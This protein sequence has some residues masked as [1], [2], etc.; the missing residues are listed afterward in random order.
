[1]RSDV[2]GEVCGAVVKVAI[3]GASG[4]V[5]GELLRLLSAHPGVQVGALTAGE[6]AGRRLGDVHPH[7]P[8]LADSVLLP[9][10]SASLAGHDVVLLALPHG[11]SAELAAVL[12]EQ[13][14]V[15]DCGADHR[16]REAA[17]WESFYGT[18]HP[19]TWV[20]G[21]PELSGQREE[22]ADARR[23]A[24]PGCFPTATALALAP[25][26]TQGLVD[27]ADVVV[28]AATGT[29]GAGRTPRQDLLGSEVMGSASAYGV[30][31]THR[32]TPE[33]EQVLRM[34]GASGAT[35]SFTPVLVPMA[36]G[37]LATCS[38]PV[39]DG[40]HADDV[41][42]AYEKATAEEPFWHLLPPGRWPQSQ[43]VIGSNSAQVQVALDAHAGRVVAV[44]AIDNLTKGTAG[45]AMQSMNIALGLPETT[46]L[47]VTGVAP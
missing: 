18:P 36:R 11:H 24:V 4:Y 37:I 5:G 16:L 6:H 28:V 46:G 7:L 45:G 25:A 8:H 23:I 29:S 42:A 21:L 44:A 43:A 3:A 2:E 31:G 26:V 27:T 41:H 10:S 20:Y 13:T 34:A 22:I 12:G 40:V 32:H 39:V 1:M 19:G 33:I 30:G 9:T 47:P 38:A 35:V 17:D 15:L 14:L